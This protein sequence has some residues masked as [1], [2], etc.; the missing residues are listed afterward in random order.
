[1]KSLSGIEG[2]T[3]SIRLVRT[4]KV[5]HLSGEPTHKAYKKLKAEGLDTHNDFGKDWVWEK[6]HDG[7]VSFPQIQIIQR[8]HRT[9]LAGS[10]AVRNL[11]TRTL[12]NAIL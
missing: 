9:I 10:D 11:M 7:M 12:K 1:M 8:G 5:L 3:L 4:D 2:V 6:E